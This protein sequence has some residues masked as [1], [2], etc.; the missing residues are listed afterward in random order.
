MVLRGSGYQ[1]LEVPDG[2]TLAE[3]LD[4]YR[5]DLVILDRH[6]AVGPDGCELARLLRLR[7]DLPVIF[8]TGAGSVADRLAGFAAGAD[9]YLVRPYATAELLA[10]LAALLR[11]SGRLLSP[12][13]QV[14]DLLVD[15]NARSVTR[16]GQPVELTRTEY[17]LLTV[18]AQHVGTVQSKPRLLA[19]VWGLGAYDTNLVEVHMSALRRKLE[20]A[21]PRIIATIRGDGYLLLAPR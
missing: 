6:F 15:D 1:V 21:G 8:V 3:H 20:A 2:L 18:L 5:P 14:G 16:A 4:A 17:D 13:W 19:Q 7:S 9:D 11:R 10:R 12:V